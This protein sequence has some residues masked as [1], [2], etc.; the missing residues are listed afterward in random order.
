MT[1][2]SKLAA[3]FALA[4]IV[5]GCS[6]SWWPFGRSSGGEADRVPAGA[7]E[8]TCAEG[9]RLLVRFAADGKSAWVFLPEREFRLDQSSS[10]ERFSNGVTTLSLSGDTVHL[11]SESTRQFADCKRKSS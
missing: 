8:Y 10:G 6:G 11:D 1:R 7:T 2:A 5:N 3:A 4:F 9:K